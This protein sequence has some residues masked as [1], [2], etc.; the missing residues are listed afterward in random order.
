MIPEL[1]DRSIFQRN[2]VNS[3]KVLRKCKYEPFAVLT[4]GPD[5]FFDLLKLILTFWNDSVNNPISINFFTLDI[6]IYIGSNFCAGN[7]LERKNRV[8][9]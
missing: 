5:N 9:S 4:R 3:L 7:E 6:P 2:L 1:R 8:I